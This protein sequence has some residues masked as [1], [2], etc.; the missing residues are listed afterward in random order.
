MGRNADERRAAWMDETWSQE[1]AH[2]DR[3]LIQRLAAASVALMTAGLLAGL[4]PA[5]AGLAVLGF[6]GA[7]VFGGVM[8]A[9]HY[10]KRLFVKRPPT[11]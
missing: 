4:W 9:C 8:L 5:A 10:D 1:F 7:G 3:P 11:P 6:V 2:C